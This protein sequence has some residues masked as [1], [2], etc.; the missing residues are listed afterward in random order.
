M[1][2]RR[3]HSYRLPTVGERETLKVAGLQSMP[4]FASNETPAFLSAGK[5]AT[6]H[7]I[8][9]SIR[10]FLH[11]NSLCVVQQTMRIDPSAHGTSY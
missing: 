4:S 3:R 7:Q 10:L 5:R 6:E 11:I 1:A 8:S 9:F 2:D